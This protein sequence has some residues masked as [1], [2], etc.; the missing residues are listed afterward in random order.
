MP[1]Q[2]VVG[3]T[4]IAGLGT[5]VMGRFAETVVVHVLTTALTVTLPAPPAEPAPAVRVIELVMLVPVTVAGNDH[6]YEVAPGTAATVYVTP[7]PPA[8]MVALPEGVG[9]VLLTATV[10]LPGLGQD[11]RNACTLTLPGPPAVTVIEW[12][13]LVPVHPPGKVQV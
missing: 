13:V 11:P 7:G 9:V 4:V 5:T 1:A 8:Q 12:V 6:R 3:P 10:W 2:E